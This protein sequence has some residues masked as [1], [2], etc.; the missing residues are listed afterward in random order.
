MLTDKVK[1]LTEY[2]KIVLMR[3]LV[4]QQHPLIV[5]GNS[6]LKNGSFENLWKI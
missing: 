1:K 2:I 5:L 3:H 6:P 4:I